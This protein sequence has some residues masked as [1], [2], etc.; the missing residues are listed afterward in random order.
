MIT[1]N[2]G[3][4]GNYL[5]K[6]DRIKADIRILCQSMKRVVVANGG[7]SSGKYVTKLPSQQLSS[8]ASQADT[9]E[10]YHQH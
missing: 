8:S 1:Y 2:P 10:S 7:T 5:S 9:F 4:N 3:A 6:T